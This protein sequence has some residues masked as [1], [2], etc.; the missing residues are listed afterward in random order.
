MFRKL[1]PL[2]LASLG[3]LGSLAL[4]LVFHGLVIGGVLPAGLV[5]GGMAV[6][7]HVNFLLLEAVALAVTLLFMTLVLFRSGVF[8]RGRTSIMVTTGIWLMFGY[9][10]LSA[11]AN[12]ASGTQF[13]NWFFA[14]GSAI[15]AILTLR[16]ALE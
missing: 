13:D 16:L 9:L 10:T 15:L 1:I 5:W 2:R 4:V 12:V 11:V 6:G 14:P 7:D 8:E 3:L